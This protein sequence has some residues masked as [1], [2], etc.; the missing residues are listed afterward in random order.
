MGLNQ[1]SVRLHRERRRH[2]MGLQYAICCRTYQFSIHKNTYQIRTK[3][4]TNT[5]T[6]RTWPKKIRMCLPLSCRRK[7]V[8]IHTYSYVFVRISVRIVYVLCTYCTYSYVSYVFYTPTGKW[9]TIRTQYV[10]YVRYVRNT[11]ANTYVNTY[12]I[13]TIRTHTYFGVRPPA[14]RVRV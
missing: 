5:Y 12:A 11:Y 14:R 2:K 13:R 7:N 9:Q 3:I 1:Q 4:R 8:R 10:R 6:I